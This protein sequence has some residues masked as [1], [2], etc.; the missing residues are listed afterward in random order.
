MRLFEEI[1]GEEVAFG[2]AKA[3][4]L[5]GRCA[6]FE[7][8]RSLLSFTEEEICVLTASGTLTVSGTGLCI[9]RYGGGDLVVRGNV[10]RVEV[11]T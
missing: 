6:C 7:N 1:L 8:V 9:A 5:A 2:G 11:M 10:L 4:M 3:V